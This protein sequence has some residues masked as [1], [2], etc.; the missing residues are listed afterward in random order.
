[1]IR[2]IA[3]HRDKY[4]ADGCGRFERQILVK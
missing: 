3:V 1:L 2:E 4:V